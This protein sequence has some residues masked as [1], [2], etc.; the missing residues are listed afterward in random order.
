MLT[1]IRRIRVTPKLRYYIALAR[2]ANQMA[3]QHGGNSVYDLQLVNLA[4]AVLNQLR[5]QEAA[6][7][8]RLARL[9]T[10]P[11]PRMAGVVE[12]QLRRRRRA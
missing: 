12:V 5:R 11:K 1:P 10:L 2:R 4:T 8:R 3:D 9:R 6:R 7:A